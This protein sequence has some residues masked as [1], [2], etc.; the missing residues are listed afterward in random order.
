MPHALVAGTLS[1]RTRG[2]GG[3]GTDFDLA[4]GLQVA[5]AFD[6]RQSDVCQYGDRTG[7]LDTD[8]STIGVLLHGSDG[9]TTTAEFTD[10]AGALTARPPGNTQNSTTTAV[11]ATMAVR[12]LTP[13]E[14]ERLQGLPD[15]YTAIPGAADGPRYKAI[16]NGMAVPVVRWI[17]QRIEAAR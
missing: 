4:G 10:T 1:A 8:G 5:H 11:L 16:G 15:D 3:L 6:A 13:R 14:T 2:G 12:R 17:G 9:H 7:P